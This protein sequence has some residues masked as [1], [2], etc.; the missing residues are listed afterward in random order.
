MILLLQSCLRDMRLALQSSVYAT[1]FNLI[2]LFMREIAIV[3]TFSVQ[4]VCPFV[5]VKSRDFAFTSPTSNSVLLIK[6]LEIHKFIYHV[7]L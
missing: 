5:V 7:P 4:R 6:Y 3:L 1:F 2:I